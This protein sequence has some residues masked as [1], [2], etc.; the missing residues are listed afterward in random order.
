MK[1]KYVRIFR[2]SDVI[3][4]VSVKVILRLR[5]RIELPTGRLVCVLAVRLIYVRLISGCDWKQH[6]RAH[7]TKASICAVVEM[8]EFCFL[9]ELPEISSIHDGHH[10]TK[11]TLG[12]EG[13]CQ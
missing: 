8:C 6:Q 1:P 12:L 9:H 10:K 4:Y 2:V 13:V 7:F 3:L 5:I 11:L